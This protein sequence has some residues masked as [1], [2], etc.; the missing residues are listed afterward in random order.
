MGKSIIIKGVIPDER[1]DQGRIGVDQEVWMINCQPEPPRWDRWFQ[2]HGLGHIHSKHGSRELARLAQ[3]SMQKPVY[4][5]PTQRD[6]WQDFFLYGLGKSEE[7]QHNFQEFPIEQMC[8][9]WGIRYFTG[10]FALL[11][12]F[13]TWLHIN[14]SIHVDSIEFAGTNLWPDPKHPQ[15]PDE[16]WAVPCVEFWLSKAH[17]E[18]I[19]I[20]PDSQ[21][22]AIMHDVWGGLYGYEAGGNE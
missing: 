10:S 1:T 4:L 12:A 6:K 3:M 21:I 22:T 8:A 13:A 11:V 15:Y 5:Y 17:S 16:H 9:H 2:L 18:G 20:Y 19:R 7:P 14:G